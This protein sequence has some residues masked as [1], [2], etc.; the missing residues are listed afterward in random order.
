MGRKFLAD[1]ML[2]RLAKWLRVMGCDTH[3]Q[4]SYGP[5]QIISFVKGGRLL[6]TRNSQLLSRSKGAVFVRPDRVREQLRDLHRQGW[7]QADRKSWFTRCVLCN[8][9]LL[10]A[11][12][13]SARE[14]VP[15]HVF[16]NSPSGIS[17]CP[18]CNRFFWPGSHRQN[19][20]AQLEAWG[21]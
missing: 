5:G 12:L 16:F 19:M 9:L 3:Y 11:P 14:N 10:D 2:G 6:L 15:E 4:P 13:E 18:S 21:F 17:F 7:I 20:L 8:E 1:A